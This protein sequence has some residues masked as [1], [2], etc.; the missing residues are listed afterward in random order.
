MQL[1]YKKNAVLKKVVY[2]K[3]DNGV[4]VANYFI[5]GKYIVQINDIQDEVSASIYGADI[6]GMI[7]MSSIRND[8]E[9]FLKDKVNNSSDNISNYFM[10]FNNK[11]YKIIS[12]KE[13]F[14]DIKVI[15]S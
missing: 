6:C 12:V 1:R 9:K 5:V 11:L 7:R 10:E 2:Q 15:E 4:K 13:E 14:I 3:Q 8:L